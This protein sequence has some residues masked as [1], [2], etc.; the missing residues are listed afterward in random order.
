[1]TN[2]LFDALF[3]PLAARADTLLILPHGGRMTGQGFLALVAR[4]AHA[5][6]AAG[7]GAGDRIA[8]QVAKSPEALA[9]YGAAVALGAIFLPLNTAYTPDEVDYFLGNATPRVFVCDPA[10]AAALAPLAARQDPKL[11]EWLVLVDALRGAGRARER[12]L[13]EQIV[14]KRL[15]Y[16]AAR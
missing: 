11:Y 8:V 10:K 15:D 4:Q 2:T 7:L 12:E 9:I 16:G 3:A 13:A 5:L 6:R 1:M 14:R